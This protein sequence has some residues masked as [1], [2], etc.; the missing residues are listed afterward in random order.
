[1]A[2]FCSVKGVKKLCYRWASLKP[3]KLTVW[4]GISCW[5]AVPSFLYLA[6]LGWAPLC[7]AKAQ[8]KISSQI[9]L[10]GLMLLPRGHLHVEGKN[11]F[12][13]GSNS[14]IPS[15]RIP[16]PLADAFLYYMQTHFWV[17]VES[18]SIRDQFNLNS[19]FPTLCFAYWKHTGVNTA[20]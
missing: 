16:S 4:L 10:E 3:P 19:L 9:Q 14:L 11:W 18:F 2:E 17:S 6:A 20:S 13:E 12:T 5:L 8:C 7:T 1:M 15:A